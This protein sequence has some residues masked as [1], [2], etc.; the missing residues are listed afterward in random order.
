MPAATTITVKAIKT[1]VVVSPGALLDIFCPEGGLA[2]TTL[3]LRTPER[4]L[5]VELASTSIRKAQAMI[6]EHG[7]D[8]CYEMIQGRLGAS[9]RIVDA[10]LVVQPRA[11]KVAAETA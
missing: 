8:A 11:S 2:R 9:D 10:G 4:T 5:E 1:A 7:P 6:T 3:R